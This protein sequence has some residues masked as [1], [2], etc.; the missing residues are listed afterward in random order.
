MDQRPHCSLPQL[1]IQIFLALEL[2]AAFQVGNLRMDELIPANVSGSPTQH[3][4]FSISV[5]SWETW[6]RQPWTDGAPGQGGG[7]G[8]AAPGHA[9]PSGT[10]KKKTALPVPPRAV[11]TEERLEGP[12]RATSRKRPQTLNCPYICQ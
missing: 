8:G 5:L 11:T 9:W 1:P 2:L 4:H 7:L 12:W 6:R 10:D 3:V